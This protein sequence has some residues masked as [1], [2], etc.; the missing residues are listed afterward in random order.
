L[1]NTAC[2][3][4]DINEIFLQPVNIEGNFFQLQS[5]LQP[6]NQQQVNTAFSNKWEDY[7]KSDEK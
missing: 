5:Q 7:Q 1:K 6:V 4:I 3:K 2:L